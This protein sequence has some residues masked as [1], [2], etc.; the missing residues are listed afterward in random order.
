MP[1]E[2]TKS[3]IEALRR[4]YEIGLNESAEYREHLE[5]IATRCGWP[6]AAVSAVYHLQIRALRLKPWQAPPCDCR[7]DE[8]GPGYGCS[9]GEVMLRRRMLKAKISLYEPNPIEALERVGIAHANITSASAK[10]VHV[11]RKNRTSAPAAGA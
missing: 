1:M 6:E 7:S 3:D 2:L 8:T 10:S 11:G 4:G 5:S 9:P